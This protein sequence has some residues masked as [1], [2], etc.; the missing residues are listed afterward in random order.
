MEMRSL[1]VW[2]VWRSSET[3][4]IASASWTWPLTSVAIIRSGWMTARSAAAMRSI[5]PSSANSFIRKPTEP[6]FMP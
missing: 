2:R 4:L 3:S 1:A 5:R 6:R